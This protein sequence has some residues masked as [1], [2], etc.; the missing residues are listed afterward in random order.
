MHSIITL[1]SA[2]LSLGRLDCDSLSD[3]A[4]MEILVDGL[5]DSAKTKIKNTK[6]EYID[7]CDWPNITCNEDGRVIEVESF[8]GQKV[9]KIAL[10]FLPP[11]VTKVSILD[12][13]QEVHIEGTLRTS[14]LPAQIKALEIVN[15]GISGQVELK[16]LPESLTQ[17]CLSYNVFTG[18]C[19][20]TELPSALIRLEINDNKLSGSISLE[21]L[22]KTIV[23]LC[24]QDNKLDGELCFD[25]LPASLGELDI[26]NNDFCGEFKLL[27]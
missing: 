12:F 19:D 10:E 23:V 14:L 1:F 9:G 24:L 13:T 21:N 6:D 7:V 17:V 18:S 25:H 8:Q 16:G 26:A 5:C 2:D 3:Q 27:G 20:L 4:L 22:P 11:L 15:I